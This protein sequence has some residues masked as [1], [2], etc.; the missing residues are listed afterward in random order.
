MT[1]AKMIGPKGWKHGQIEHRL[2]Q[3]ASTAPLSYDS[4]THSC[5]ACLSKGVSVQRFFG[6]EKLLISRSGRCRAVA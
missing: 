3:T 6:F 2:L 5:D 1:M 4:G